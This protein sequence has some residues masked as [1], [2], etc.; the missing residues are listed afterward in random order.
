MY[1]F[2]TYNLSLCVSKDLSLFA[3]L[4]LSLL[5]EKK[6]KIIIIVSQYKAHNFSS[7][8]C[9]KILS[10]KLLEGKYCGNNYGL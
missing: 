2:H 5:H 7:P 1:I 6:K 9:D 8:F 10:S 4:C 3:E